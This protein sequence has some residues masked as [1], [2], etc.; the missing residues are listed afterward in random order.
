LHKE[1][2]EVG[3][4]A[5]DS[6]GYCKILIGIRDKEAAWLNLAAQQTSDLFDLIDRWISS[7]G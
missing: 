6:S 2:N 7:E 4:I 1:Y 5:Y 3:G